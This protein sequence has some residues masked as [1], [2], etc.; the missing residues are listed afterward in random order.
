[1][2]KQSVMMLGALAGVV[3][4]SA[5][6]MAADKGLVLVSPDEAKAETK[7]EASGMAPPAAAKAF[8]PFAP[9]IQVLVPR[10]DQP[11]KP[12]FNV[13]VE[14]IPKGNWGVNR[15][16]LKIRYGWIGLDV[17]ARMLQYG[18]WQGNAF[19]VSGAAA[20]AGTHN[21]KVSIADSAGH[22]AEAD[23]KVVVLP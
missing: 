6:A 2:M 10:I 13:R 16:S 14:V 9:S 3:L 12:P 19:I 21:F 5:P 7:A 15:Q 18:Q 8:D 17:T 1:M 23:M 11:T 4:S 20:P 22:R